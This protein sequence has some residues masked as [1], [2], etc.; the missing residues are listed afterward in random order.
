MKRIRI[1]MKVENV[2]FYLDWESG[3]DNISQTLD[4]YISIPTKSIKIEINGRTF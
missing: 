2:L 1:I 4:V 3:D